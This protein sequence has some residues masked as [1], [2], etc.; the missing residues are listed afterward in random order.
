MNNM[1]LSDIIANYPKANVL[2]HDDLDGYTSGAISVLCLKLLG[3]RKENINVVH[4][5][6]AVEFKLEPGLT[7]ITDLSCSG[8]DNRLKL[9][10]ANH[11]PENMIIWFDHHQNSVELCKEY[12]DLDSIP[13]IRNTSGCGAL[14][15]WIFYQILCN[16]DSEHMYGAT[17]LNDIFNNDP[18]LFDFYHN[19]A[20]FPYDT[21][22]MLPD[23]IKNTQIHS[24]PRTLQL[25]ND[26]DIHLTDD[27]E[28]Q[29]A[30][31]FNIAFFH[32]SRFEKDVFSHFFQKDMIPA[33]FLAELKSER[34]LERIIQAGERINRYQRY[35]YLDRLLNKGFIATFDVEGFEYVIC[36]NAKDM[37]FNSAFTHFED[38]SFPYQMAFTFVEVADKKTGDLIYQLTVY[39][40]NSNPDDPYSAKVFCSILGGGG[41][42][43]CSGA[44]VKKLPPIKFAK[45]LPDFVKD[46]IKKE[47]DQLE[48]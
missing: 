38:P 26:W 16:L 17:T 3:Y 43:G 5:S 22:W 15:A 48:I 29:N 37:N 45:P 24:L 31:Y 11:K 27:P 33:D 20:P 8:V 41:H 7:I 12:P 19:N 2:T 34:E 10:C 18:E 25:V 47:I 28:F 32:Y 21:P 23:I 13:G 30:S 44:Y 35:F 9:T 42:P 4:Q 1:Y 40:K 6:P 36:L 39:K 46:L 14:L